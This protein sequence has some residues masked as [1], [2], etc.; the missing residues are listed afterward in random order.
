MA[1]PNRLTI[2]EIDVVADALTARPGWLELARTLE[3]AAN[4]HDS[5]GLR[6][7]SMAFVYDLVAP[8]QSGRRATAGGP[9]APMWEESPDGSYPPRVPDVL[10]E[11]RNVWQFVLD[12]LDD[13]IACARL[14]DLLYV[15]EGRSAHVEGR[16]AAACLVALT[17]EPAWTALDKAV[18]IARAIEIQL[19]LNDRNG[20]EASTKR[21]VDLVDELLGQEHPG[22]PFIA[23]RA[24]I[25][26]KSDRRPVKVPELLDR[27]IEHFTGTRHEAAALGL[28]ADA[29]VDS[30]VRSV[31]RRRQ[32]DA[33]LIEARNADG[34]AKVAL[35]QRAAEFARANGLSA[36]AAT[37]L[38]EL[39]DSPQSELGFQSVEV[40]EQI[41]AEVIREEVDRLVGSGAK[42][43]FDALNRI[44][45]SVEPPGG[46]NADMDAEVARLA[47]EFPVLGLFGQTVLGPESAAPHFV[48]NDDESKRQV[49]RG[50]LRRIHTEF[51]AGVFL[52]PLFDTAVEHHGRPSHDDLAAHFATELIGPERGERFARALE[53]FWDQDYDA[54]A[55]VLVPRLESVLRDLARAHGITIVKPVS[56]GSYG[57]VISLNTIMSKLRAIEPDAEWLDYLEALL[58][59]P[60]ALNF[61][62][63]IAHGLIPAVGGGGAAL[64]LHA[65]CFLSVLRPDEDQ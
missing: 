23:L 44:G 42:D 38:K 9:Y 10:E 36:E 33:R 52:G 62:N 8:G 7:L 21:C 56:E 29:A 39:Q 54:S 24:L 64:L 14:A 18:C 46:S 11:I 41:P 48:A 26:L 59:D 19:E 47:E 45:A 15:A 12:N 25:A 50:R 16:R 60:L 32:L 57:G 17:S 55:H 53:L 2:S 5:D 27:V 43:L 28:A 30:Q 6:M 49:E 22:P 63:L 58:C 35:L 40:S 37:I 51:T 4:E 65:A 20:L 61:R 31:L 3:S 13:P 1:S 34:L